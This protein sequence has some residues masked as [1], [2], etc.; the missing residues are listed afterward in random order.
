MRAGVSP[1]PQIDLVFSDPSFSFIW[2]DE[3][4]R[5]IWPRTANGMCGGPAER[6]CQF[7]S[8][9]HI[10][11]WNLFEYKIDWK[12]STVELGRE[13]GVATGGEAAALCAAGRKTK[14]IPSL[15]EMTLSFKG[16]CK[17]AN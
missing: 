17:K 1:T 2:G 13:S 5:H 9:L 16:R 11:N 12:T 14:N 3:R 6:F 4:V 10:Q 7:R 15:D 8:F